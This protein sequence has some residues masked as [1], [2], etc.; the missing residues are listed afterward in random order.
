[1]K[2]V[3]IGLV[4]AVLLAQLVSASSDVAFFGV[5]FEVNGFNG[6]MVYSGIGR[7]VTVHVYLIGQGTHEVK[8]EFVKNVRFWFDQVVSSKV[9]MVALHKGLN[10]VVFSF[11]PPTIGEFFVRVYVDGRRVDGWQLFANNR[12]TLFVNTYYWV[13][14]R[15][16]VN[17][18]E[19]LPEAKAPV[20]PGEKVIIKGYLYKT[21]ITP[22]KSYV[23]PAVGVTIVGYSVCGDVAPVKAVTDSKGYFELHT[24]APNWCLYGLCGKKGRYMF[25]RAEVNDTPSNLRPFWEFLCTYYCPNGCKLPNTPGL[26]PTPPEYSQPSSE[27]MPTS[28][29]MLALIAGAIVVVAYYLSKKH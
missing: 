25:I 16:I 14:L 10:D 21:I 19:Y 9:K 20:E 23:V 17:G 5:K 8:V 2:K 22:K 11:R 1:M 4:L 7:S 29:A 12:P 15:M 6:K 3:L 27:Q 18:K 24:T 26:P 13:G 28:G